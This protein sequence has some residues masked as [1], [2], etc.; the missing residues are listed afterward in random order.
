[1]R[2][3]TWAHLN[4]AQRVQNR[5]SHRLAAPPLGHG[6][7]VWLAAVVHL[8]MQGVQ[9]AA[10]RRSTLR[11][12]LSRQHAHRGFHRLLVRA[13]LS[14]CRLSLLN[15]IE[16]INMRSQ[17]VHHREPEVV[18]LKSAHQ[19][20]DRLRGEHSSLERGPELTQLCPRQA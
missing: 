14:S 9:R 3:N 13:G 17:R 1:M 15:S 2:A 7:N 10:Q 12:A 11:G 18:E 4:V 19:V 8:R 20:T 6:L 5:G 16:R